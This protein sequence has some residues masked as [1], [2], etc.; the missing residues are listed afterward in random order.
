MLRGA[1]Q[2]TIV[3]EV[4][5]DDTPMPNRCTH[6]RQ[7]GHNRTTCP[8]DAW[9]AASLREAYNRECTEQARRRHLQ[10]QERQQVLNRPTPPL[11]SSE[12]QASMRAQVLSLQARL[13]VLSRASEQRRPPSS[14]TVREKKVQEILFERSE[15]LNDGL[16]KELMD[17]LVIKD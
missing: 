9:H 7:E 5:S 8:H 1:P 13:T 16:Y 3:S 6:C 17:A 12:W 2:E 11:N 14:P 10:L 4:L 15:E